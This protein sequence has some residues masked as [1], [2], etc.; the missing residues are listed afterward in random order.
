M[1][2]TNASLKLDVIQMIVKWFS[3]IPHMGVLKARQTLTFLLRF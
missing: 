1:P 2:E 3:V